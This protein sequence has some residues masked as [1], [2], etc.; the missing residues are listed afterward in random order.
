[1]AGLTLLAHF[2]ASA[3][4]VLRRSIM[5]VSLTLLGTRGTLL[6]ARER[7]S[8][9]VPRACMCAARP[10]SM[11]AETATVPMFSTINISL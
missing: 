1:M 3:N 8:S 9:A 6:L 2:E 10:A 5:L 7:R 11:A 4:R